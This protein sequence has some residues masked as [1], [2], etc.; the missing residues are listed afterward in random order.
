MIN[1]RAETLATKPSFREPFRH[2]RCI[3]P[4]DGF[5]E[6]T[7][8]PAQKTRQPWFIHQTGHEPLAFAG[9]WET[10]TGPHGKRIASCT[11]ITANAGKKMA[12]LHHRQPVFLPKNMWGPWL[13]P[14][15]TDVEELQAFLSPD[16]GIDV[17]FHPVSTEVNNAQNSGPHL[18]TPVPL[19][20]ETTREIP[21]FDWDN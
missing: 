1:A 8:E 12:R 5:Y 4:V 15:N 2:Q 14:E 3:I 13:D 6:W 9:L 7:T 19:E 11:I 10:W 20:A 18:I 21:L 17:A 16:T